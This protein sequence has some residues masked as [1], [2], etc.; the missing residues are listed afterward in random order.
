MVPE[1]IVYEGTVEVLWDGPRGEIV[2]VWGGLSDRASEMIWD[3][4]MEFPEGGVVIADFRSDAEKDDFVSPELRIRY[5]RNEGPRVRTGQSRPRDLARLDV[6]E[7]VGQQELE[8]LSD[9]PPDA[10]WDPIDDTGFAATIRRVSRSRT[11]VLALT[12]L[13]V[14]AMVRLAR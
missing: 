1:E 10:V 5:R 12:A 11:T 2:L 3:G 4:T 6:I 14:F 9:M 13:L 8:P 7:A